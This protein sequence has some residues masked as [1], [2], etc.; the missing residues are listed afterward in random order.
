MHYLIWCKQ[1]HGVK[2]VSL[3][4]ETVLSASVKTAF[5]CNINTFFKLQFLVLGTFRHLPLDTVTLSRS[6]SLAGLFYLSLYF[7]LFLS[8]CLCLFHLSRVL[9]PSPPTLSGAVSLTVT[10]CV[11]T[12][13][14]KQ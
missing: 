7:S 2:L 10:R 6:L 13:F 3:C 5:E 4:S 14:L 9:T 11:I 12:H 8:L 1:E